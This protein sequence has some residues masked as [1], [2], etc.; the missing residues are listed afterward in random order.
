LSYGN[1]TTVTGSTH[2]L[3]FTLTTGFPDTSQGLRPSFLV[4][5]GLPH[6]DAPPFVS[7]SFGNGLGMPWWQGREATRPPAYQSF[8]F[9]IQQQLNPTTVAEIAYNAALGSRLQAGLL[10]YNAIPFSYLE[11][12][13][14]TLLNSHITSAAAVNAG[15]RPPFADFAR[16]FGNN[17]TV[18]QAL[19]PFPQFQAINTSAGGGDHSGHSTYHSGQVRLEKRYSHGLQF[20]TSYV[21]SKL[22]TNADSFWPGGA[23][24]DHYNRGLEKSIGQFDVTHNFKFNAVWEVPVGR[25][26]SFLTG[27]GPGDWVLGGWR[28]SGIFNYSSGQ[29]LGLGTSNALPLFS[30]GNRPIIDRFDGWDPGTQG[31]KFDPAVDRTIQ[32]ASFFPAQP[33]NVMGNM[34][35]YNPMFRS[36]M[37]FTENMSL[38]KSFR[39]TEKTRIDFRVETFNS[40]NRVRFGMGSLNL[41]A[42]NFGVLARTASDQANS[43]RQI[44]LGLKLYF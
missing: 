39:T 2:N 9:S 27:G 19:R 14:P 17:A 6:W 29:P 24:M 30:G 43:P 3:G 28:L 32:P 33:A 25:G 40:F 26:R 44:Q 16:L 42:Q 8:N 31:N 15:F 38:A 18:R 13:G 12:F 37:I 1:I 21:F 10:A 34:T 23:A 36:R 5:D 20:L 11:R 4:R 41:Q 35:R 22:L 7:P